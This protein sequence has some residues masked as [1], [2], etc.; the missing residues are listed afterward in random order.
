[1]FQG[2]VPRWIDEPLVRVLTSLVWVDRLYPNESDR[3]AHIEG[4]RRA[5]RD[6]R[7][8]PGKRFDSVEPILNAIADRFGPEVYGRFFRACLAAARRKELELV[9]ERQMT[10]AE[11]MKYLS[12]AAGADVVP[13]FRRWNGFAAVEKS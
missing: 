1:M 13:F 10:T 3:V 5:G 12:E 11:T 8:N 6:F 9:P 2:R 4:M 7:E